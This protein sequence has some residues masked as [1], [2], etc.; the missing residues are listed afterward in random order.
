MCTG[1]GALQP[2][3][4]EEDGGG[5]EEESGGLAAAGPGR[6]DAAGRVCL[7]V[8]DAGRRPGDQAAARSSGRTGGGDGSP[9]MQSPLQRPC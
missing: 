8:A 1:R 7:A 6:G 5:G 3:G 9:E 2:P 4:D